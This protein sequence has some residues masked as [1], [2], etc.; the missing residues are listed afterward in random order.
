MEKRLWLQH[1]SQDKTIP[2]P[3]Q[4][5]KKEEGMDIN[6]EEVSDDSNRNKMFVKIMRSIEMKYAV[7][8]ICPQDYFAEQA[9]PSL[10]E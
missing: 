6:R 8:L 4:P 3:T 1:V 7:P 9:L 2:N 5:N 10:S